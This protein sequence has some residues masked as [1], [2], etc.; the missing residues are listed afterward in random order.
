[1][2][3]DTQALKFWSVVEPHA[4]DVE[5]DYVVVPVRKLCKISN[6]GPPFK[7]VAISRE[8][9][10]G[11]ECMIINYQYPRCLLDMLQRRNLNFSPA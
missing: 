2:L 5:Q 6:I 8:R 9:A 4:V 7:M 11:R 3:Q 1:V 10:L